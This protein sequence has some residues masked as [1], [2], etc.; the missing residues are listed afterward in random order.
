MNHVVTI[1]I[2]APESISHEDVR[3]VLHKLINVGLS[4]AFQTVEEEE[5][6][7]DAELAINLVIHE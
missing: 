5:Y 3:R 1:N 7:E 4:D 6:D 2:D